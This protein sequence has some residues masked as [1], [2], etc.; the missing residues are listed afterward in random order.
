MSGEDA[1]VLST[2]PG[3]A[4]VLARRN[5][6]APG[7]PGARFLRVADEEVLQLSERGVGIGG[8]LIVEGA[9][10]ESNEEVL[11]SETEAGAMAVVAREG[12]PAPGLVGAGLRAFLPTEPVFGG[13][14]WTF[15]DQT[16][17]VVQGAIFRQTDPLGLE[18]LALEGDL[19]AGA[20]P[21]EFAW[22]FDVLAANDAGD[23]L[24]DAIVTGGGNDRGI[25]IDR[26][27]GGRE[28]VL[29][30]GDPAPGIAG[31]VFSVFDTFQVGFN[32]AGEIAVRAQV[33]GGGVE[34][35]NDFGV[36][37]P[38]GAGG[39]R[40]V[41]REGDP[42]PGVPG[43][44]FVTL[45]LATLDGAGG[46]VVD[47]RLTTTTRGLWYASRGGPLAL[48]AHI[49]SPV[50]GIDGVSFA[51]MGEWEINALGQLVFEAGFVE[52]AQ[53]NEAVWRYDASSGVTERVARRGD[54]VEVAPGD[55]R[56]IEGLELA[57]HES[58]GQDGRPSGWN[59]AGQLAVVLRFEGGSEAVALLTVPEASGGS[60]LAL[61]ALALLANLR[62]RVS[63]RGD[64]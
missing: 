41:A 60:W 13:L 52:G 14:G 16:T 2:G 27:T 63:A 31:A 6:P 32:D 23:V 12:D 39:L 51:S 47:A 49:G 37:A 17:G 44:S 57:E 48:V 3:D 1:V 35:S 54:L 62:T 33:T 20:E 11:W 64:R 40:L 25:W 5:D 18:L 10:T 45:S 55:A 38:D 46:V 43:E 59:D 61:A 50:P 30:E 28:I 21:R 56:S 53:F 58:G 34:A 19:A 8:R 22:P 29:F 4:T 15:E 7:I 9:V 24:F 36:W 26:A 42:A